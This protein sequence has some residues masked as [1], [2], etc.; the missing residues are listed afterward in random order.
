[1]VGINTPLEV[2][3]YHFKMEYFDMFDVSELECAP[4]YDNYSADDVMLRLL[5]LKDMDKKS[6]QKLKK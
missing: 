6:Y 5:S 3:T 2:A 4:K 1:M